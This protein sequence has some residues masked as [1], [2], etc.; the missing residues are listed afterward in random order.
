MLGLP[1]LP[2]AERRA[3]VADTVGY[4]RALWSL[5]PAYEGTHHRFA[6]VRA[7]PPPAPV[8]PIV[9]GANG[10]RLAALAGRIADGVN[11]HNGQRDRDGVI[12]AALEHAGD[13]PFEVSVE[14][15]FDAAWLDPDGDAR[16]H[17]EA[18]GVQRVMARWSPSLGLGAFTDPAR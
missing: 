6:D 4:L 7:V 1:V 16:N 8:P 2:A 12:A 11:V 17:L 15:P 3:I 5:E 18:V 14:G 13:R 9:I 10:P